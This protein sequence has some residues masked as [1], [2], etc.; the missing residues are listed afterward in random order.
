VVCQTQRTKIVRIL[1]G[2]ECAWP[3]Q[4]VESLRRA[5]PGSGPSGACHRLADPQTLIAI[6]KAKLDQHQ[7]L[8]AGG[9][10]AATNSRTHSNVRGPGLLPWTI[11]DRH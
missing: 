4:S 9:T 5:A 6:L 10:A 2:I 3:A 11:D 8:F 7:D 1:N